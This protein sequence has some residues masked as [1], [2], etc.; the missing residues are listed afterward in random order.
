MRVGILEIL[1]LPSQ[2]WA[3]TIYNSI[4]TR[5]F[6]SITPQAISVWCRQLGHETFYATYYGVGDVHYLLPPDLDVIFITCYTQVSP[7][8]YALAKIYRQAGT[9][10]IIG[11]PHAKSFPVDCLRFFDLV[12]RECDRDLIVDILAGHFDPGAFISSAKPFDDLPTV[13]E[14]MPEI[15][16]SAFFRGKWPIFGFVV[17]MLA[18]TGCPYQCNFCIDWDNPYRLLPTDRLAADL[19]YLARNFPDAVIGFHDPNFAIKFDQ[20]FDTLEAILPDSRISY[21]MECSLSILHESRI[22]RLKETNCVAV[23]PGIESWTDY[24]NK[25]GLGRKGGLEKVN[26]VVEH[27]QLLY[28]YVPYMQANFIF[29]LDTDI[30]DDP[31]TLTKR[32]MDHTPFVWPAVNIPVPFGGTPLYR[33]LLASG[34]ILKAMPFCFYYA[35]YLVTT[36]KNYEPVTYYE[37]LLELFSFSS[38][39][40]MLKRRLKS[41]SNRKIKLIHWGRTISTKAANNSYQRILEMLRSDPQFRA[42]HEGQSEVLP[43]FYHK[44]Y[45]RMLGPYAELLSQAD[46]APNLEQLTPM[47]SGS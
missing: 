32:F 33:Q 24:S 29:G 28:G 35:P 26:Q 1:A 6:A 10:T 4:L 12:V 47:L 9:R 31:I 45:E 16:A 21:I 41:A 19:G 3:D 42:F 20:V 25:A 34:R 38:S 22:K 8:A 7:M 5:Q 14:R 40:T 17:P 2:Y 15:R 30:G 27:F 11:G 39:N 44:E 18:S 36:L 43:E 46:R 37:K 13:E 23:L